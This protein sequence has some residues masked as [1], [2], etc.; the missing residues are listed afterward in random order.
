MNGLRDLIIGIATIGALAAGI[1]MLV[2]F[3][4]LDRLTHPRYEVTILVDQAAG[5]RP[6]STVELNGVPIGIVDDLSLGREAAYPVVVTTLID[7]DVSIATDVEPYATTSLLGTASILALEAGTPNGDIPTLPRDGTATVRNTIKFRMIEQIT[8]EL[9][10]RM[11]P[12]VAAL[13]QFNE[14]SRAYTDLGTNLNSLIETSPDG[15]VGVRDALVKIYEVI[16]EIGEATK[17]ARSW[18]EDDQ[19]RTDATRAIANAADLTEKASTT[20]DNISELATALEEDADRAVERVLP[21]A[22]QLAMTLEEVRRLTLLAREGEGS[23]GL[24]LN[25]PELYFALED[26]AVRLDRTL[27]E[28]QMLIEKLRKEGVKVGL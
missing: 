17:L 9:D 1:V 19:I 18:L 23:I 15:E 8:T 12:L 27:R 16:D 20:L 2:L 26:V 28:A 7:L 25:R 24:L 21:V 4:E 10:S 22:D 3:G 6:G 5:L 13:D 11:E 14:L